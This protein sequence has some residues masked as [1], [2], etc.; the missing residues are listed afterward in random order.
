MGIF[1]NDKKG[2]PI[3]G[4]PTPRLLPTKVEGLPLCKE[5]AAKI[6][7]ESSM[8]KDLT[9]NELWDHLDYRKANSETF[10]TPVPVWDEC[11]A[12]SALHVIKDAQS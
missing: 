2:C 4:N 1:S 3:C 12:S 9:I 6:N 11:T 8:L 7:M 10:G 5:C